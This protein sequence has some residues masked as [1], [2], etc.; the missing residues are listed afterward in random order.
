MSSDIACKLARNAGIAMILASAAFLSACQVRPLYSESSGVTEKLSSVGFSPAGSR[1]E[2]QVRN[3]LI[4]LSSRGAGEPEKP[5]YLVEMHASSTVAD[6]LLRESGDTSRAG[7]V[8]VSVTYTLRAATDNHVIKAGS[9]ATTALVDFP[10]Q[11]FAKQRAI[12][13]AQN[14]AADQVAEFVGADIAAALSR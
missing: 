11:E 3:H 10:D 7:R 1:V 4:F 5:E 8:T 9:R 13:D 2:Q 12:R 6:T 14:R